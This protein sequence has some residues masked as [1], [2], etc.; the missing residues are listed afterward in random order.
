MEST[1]V[2]LE[3]DDERPQIAAALRR[4]SHVFDTMV[5]VSVD[6]SFPERLQGIASRNDLVQ[7]IGTV[8]VLRY[9]SLKT[10]NLAPDFPQP[11]DKRVLFTF[12]MDMFHG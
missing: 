6:D 2:A 4:V 10:L 11:E 9:Q 1:D 8:R 5:G 3:N 7:N 12:G